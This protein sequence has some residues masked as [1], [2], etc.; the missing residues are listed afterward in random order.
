MKACTYHV[1]V[2]GRRKT[3]KTRAAAKRAAGKGVV[4]RVCATRGLGAAP[5]KKRARNDGQ[6]E[7]EALIDKRVA[8]NETISRTLAPYRERW[9]AALEVADQVAIHGSAADY[10]SAHA[11]VKAAQHAYEAKQK[12]LEAKSSLAGTRCARLSKNKKRC[13][14]RTSR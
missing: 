2:K 14:K 9:D 13:L 8:R 6:K 10:R 1:S 12:E 3:F 5:K 7:W 4:R 11:D